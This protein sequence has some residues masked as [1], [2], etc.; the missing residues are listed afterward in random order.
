MKYIYLSCHRDLLYTYATTWAPAVRLSDYEL[1][2]LLTL[3]WLILRVQA[4]RLSL[5]QAASVGQDNSVYVSCSGL[6]STAASLLQLAAGGWVTARLVRA[7]ARLKQRSYL[8]S[9]Q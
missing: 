4:G 5:L 9:S 3:A 2:E 6:V 1:E 7:V 8:S